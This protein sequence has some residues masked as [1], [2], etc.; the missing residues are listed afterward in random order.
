MKN[1]TAVF[2]ILFLPAFVFAAGEKTPVKADASSE[3]EKGAGAEIKEKE[4]GAAQEN[5]WKDPVLNVNAGVSQASFD[6]WAQGGQPSFSWQAGLDAGIT[7]EWEVINWKNFLSARYGESTYEGSGPRKTVDEIKAESTGALKILR[8]FGPYIAFSWRT[9]IAP[10]YEYGDDGDKTEIS[11]F[12]DPGYF[13]ESAGIKYEPADFLTTR[14]G[15]GMKHTA[16]QLYGERFIGEKNETIKNEAGLELTAEF[17]KKF[18]ENFRIKSKIDL[19]SDFSATDRIDVDW[20]NDATLKMN[21]IFNINFSYRILYDRD[22]SPLRQ[23]KQ[24]LT[25]GASYSFI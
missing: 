25:A 19:F 4:T 8:M 23:I 20:E 6:N 13:R 21:D 11:R 17:N 2:L 10:G 18:T 16:A 14:M 1:F 5:I 12:M 22:I 7:G 3:T 24:S 15:F 9:Q